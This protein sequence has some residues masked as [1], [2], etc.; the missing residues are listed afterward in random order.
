M[1][2]Y[3]ERYGAFVIIFLVAF[4]VYCSNQMVGATISK[5]AN[6]MGATSTLI[7]TVAGSFQM[8]ALLIRPISGQTVDHANKKKLLFFSMFIILIS[9]VGLTFSSTVTSIILFRGINGLGWGIGSTLLMT[10]ATNFFPKEKTNTG[11]AIYSMG[12]TIAQAIAPTIALSIVDMQGFNNL[13]KYNS[14]LMLGACILTLFVQIEDTSDK[15]Y[16]YSFKLENM[17]AKE[18]ILPA[19][20]QFCNQISNAAITAFLVL[21]AEEIGIVNVGFYYTIRACILFAFRPL[22]ASLADRLGT[23]RVLVPCE[24]L[25][26]LSFAALVVA[27]GSFEFV[28]S[29]I[30]MGISMSGSHPALMSLCMNSVE[31]ERRGVASNTNYLVTDLGGFLGSNVAGAIAGFVGYRSLFAIFIIPLVIC[32]LIY[33]LFI[34]KKGFQ[35]I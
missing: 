35:G 17:I 4:L 33:L 32:L 18:A 24:I 6:Y 1:K 27:Q 23:N 14:V 12:Q 15:N 16:K 13:Y 22:I 31:K 2:R 28:I 34:K 11:I 7:G 29:A 9:T 21:Y 19:T 30:F 3:I 5:F 26:I 20:L 8:V 10:L 25:Q